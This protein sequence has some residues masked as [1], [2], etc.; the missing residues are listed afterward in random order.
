MLVAFQISSLILFSQAGSAT[1]AQKPNYPTVFVF[2]GPVSDPVEK[3]K[4][5]PRF[6][7][8]TGSKSEIQSAVKLE[9]CEVPIG[10]FTIVVLPT[11]LIKNVSQYGMGELLTEIAF[12][13]DSENVSKVS[14]PQ[15]HK[16]LT[17]FALKLASPQ[18]KQLLASPD[19]DGEFRVSPTY[20]VDVNV[21]GQSLRITCEAAGQNL[22][23]PKPPNAGHPVKPWKGDTPP[24]I[25]PTQVLN[26]SILSN[27]NPYPG[28]VARDASKAIELVTKWVIEALKE[29]TKELCK[30]GGLSPLD[31]T[32]TIKLKDV[33]EP[34]RST[35]RAGLILEASDPSS[36]IS[37]F[38]R[39]PELIEFKPVR[40][41]ATVKFGIE[42][43]SGLSVSF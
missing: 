37:S 11:E 42:G 36:P 39:H 9:E 30:S 25:I 40:R 15:L 38:Y 14:N 35:I 4:P 2:N 5:K 29:E 17:N 21:K 6:R 18:E 7:F 32:K 3:M 19:A 24:P 28:Y 1:P 8:A 12:L 26:Y 22:R 23:E 10:N 16:K 34:L 27:T 20:I 33:P 31:P 13:E 43:S 41:G